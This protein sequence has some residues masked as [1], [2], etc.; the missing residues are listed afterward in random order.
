MSDIIDNK[1]N[2]ALC[3][4]A[5]MVCHALPNRLTEDADGTVTVKAGC[6]GNTDN[7]FQ[8]VV[9]AK[10]AAAKQ[11]KASQQNAITKGHQTFRFQVSGPVEVELDT[12]KLGADNKP[13]VLNIAAITARAVHPNEAVD[14]LQNACVLTGRVVKTKFGVELQFGH[15]GSA[16]DQELSPAAAKLA[17]VSAKEMEPYADQDVMV[18]G[19]FSRQTKEEA[20]G[21]YNPYDHVSFKVDSAQVI[22]IAAGRTRYKKGPKTNANELTVPDY[23]SGYETEAQPSTYSKE[24]LADLDF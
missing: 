4:M 18:A 7:T 11:L 5:T 3:G 17:S 15:L 19:T 16:I 2:A 6:Q 9:R 13:L 1:T 20:E 22:Q 23:E 8:V 12:N 24:E 21:G 10:E 14:P